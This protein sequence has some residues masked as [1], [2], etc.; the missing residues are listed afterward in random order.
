M[1]AIVNEDT[2]KLV[3]ELI[4]NWDALRKMYEE[5]LKAKSISDEQENEFMKLRTWLIRRSQLLKITLQ[6]LYSL[7][8]DIFGVLSALSSFERLRQESPII[9][10]NIRTRW[11]EAFISA[12]KLAGVVREKLEHPGLSAPVAKKKGK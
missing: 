4:I 9:Q 11:H 8:K 1:A 3:Q 6:E 7:H 5:G 10:D 12:N 2:P